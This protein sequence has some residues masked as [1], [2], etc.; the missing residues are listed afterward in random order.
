[1]KYFWTYV[2]SAFARRIYGLFLVCALL[3]V[4]A[5]ALISWLQVSDATRSESM[6]QLR[7]AGKNAGI[8]VME[9]LYLLENELKAV[10]GALPRMPRTGSGGPGNTSPEDVR[11]EAFTVFSRSGSGRRLLGPLCVRPPLTPGALR[12]LA[13]G[14]TL[15]FND[16]SPKDGGRLFMALALKS[17]R[18]AEE[19]LVGEIRQE[20][21]WTL[22][23][24]T[25]LPETELCILDSSGRLLFNSARPIPRFIP[26]IMEKQAGSSVGQLE[27]NGK[28]KHSLVSYWTAFLTPLYHE[29]PWIVAVSQDTDVALRP[30]RLFGRSFLL[31]ICL[32]LIVI[33]YLSSIMIRRNLVPLATL[34]KGTQ[35]LSQGD[36]SARVTL[37][38]GDEFEEL[39]DTFNGMAEHLQR[40]FSAIRE[41]G[42]V[43]QL[44]LAAHN[45]A[46]IVKAALSVRDTAVPCDALA[47]SLIVPDIVDT[48]VTYRDSGSDP[49]GGQPSEA[50]TTFAPNELLMLAGNSGYLHVIDDGRFSALLQPMIEEGMREFFLFPFQRQDSLAGILTIGYRGVESPVQEN[51]IHARKITD[52]IGVALDN[53]R[54]IEELN[55]LNWGTISALANAVDAKSHWTAGHS[56]RV[57]QLSMA[58]GRAMGLS[59]EEL[60]ILHLGGMLH[61]MGKIAVPESILDKKGSLTE[62][63]YALIK[64]HPEVG[65][66]ILRPIHAYAGILPLVAQHHEWFNGRGYPRGLAG[67]DIALGARILAV[68]D[69]FDAL[70]SDRPYRSSW[71]RHRVLS[72]I[73]ERAGS[74][75]DPKVVRALLA[76]E[77][78]PAVVHEPGERVTSAVWGGCQP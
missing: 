25:L 31:I 6:E 15:L 49:A 43:I 23:G 12:H 54:L 4:C 16:A 44:F 9:G 38:S 1:M 56:G 59:R 36:L 28:G 57:T 48:A 66:R 42:R 76:L 68:A 47:L 53:V 32:T 41:T 13:E 30:I 62:E 58:I 64:T 29:R 52:V 3:P 70:D 45:R 35:Q 40:Q 75:F 69:V 10:A 55:Q 37:C 5:L 51:L 21:L 61:D 22:V 60:E 8:T 11:F 65:A 24:H 72:H 27:W 39:A 77:T 71:E 34:R 2:R 74:Q 14:K 73:E 20:F 67:D 46:A 17:G 18:P 78:E 33:G 19:L 7:H 50:V 26:R 63:E